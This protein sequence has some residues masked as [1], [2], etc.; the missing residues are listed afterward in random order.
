L[1]AKLIIDIRQVLAQQ[2]HRA[3]GLRA[4]ALLAHYTNKGGRKDTTKNKEE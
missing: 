4:K 1:T 2:Q 3:S